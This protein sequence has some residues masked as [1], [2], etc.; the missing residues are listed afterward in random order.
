MSASINIS[1]RGIRRAATARR[2]RLGGRTPFARRR[3]NVF[4]PRPVT[5]IVQRQGER[6]FFDSSFN[7]ASTNTWVT[8]SS[9]ICVPTQ[10][11]GNQNRLGQKISI[12]SMNFRMYL[13]MNAVEAQATPSP[14]ILSRVI[15]GVIRPGAGV[16]VGDVVDTGATAD[17]LA[18]R[19]IDNT[20]DFMILKDFFIKVDPHALNE[21][22][23]N[24]FAHGTSISEVIKFTKVW[25]KP[26]PMKFVTASDVASQNGIFIMA[27]SSA[28]GAVLNI[29]TR[30]RFTDS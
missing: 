15:V 23:V 29:E 19:Q 27:I 26:M 10:G 12:T 4:V 8:T 25:K 20:S 11:T 18:Y 13:S 24:A 7:N 16:T 5:I 1:Q 6:K 2:K 17:L 30:T 9:N 21:G 28:T 14:T 3:P 22:A